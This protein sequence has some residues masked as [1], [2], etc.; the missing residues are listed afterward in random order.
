MAR[1]CL[2][3]GKCGEKVKAKAKAKKAPQRQLAKTP[4]EREEENRIQSSDLCVWENALL[5]L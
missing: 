2:S 4:K 3:L 1:H 5:P